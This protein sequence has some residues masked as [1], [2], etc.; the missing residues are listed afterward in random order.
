VTAQDT[1]DPTWE[2]PPTDQ[3]VEYGDAFNYDLDASDLSDIS[4]WEINDTTNFNIDS[5]GVIRNVVT[6]TV[7]EYWLEVQAYDPYDN[8]CNVT[9][10]I[11]VQD[12]TLPNW[13]ITPLDQTTECGNAFNCDLD[14]SDLS[15]ISS[16]EINDT[17]NF[18]IDS[19]GIITN[20]GTLAV[21]EYGLEV[22]DN[23]CWNISC[24]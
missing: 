17:T 22:H 12:T 1:T 8:F 15:G 19:N 7:G 4:N 9:L 10:K 6:L 18:N 2:T 16:W 20:V 13:S 5:S 24:R 11:T 23:K 21:G 3:A 14:A